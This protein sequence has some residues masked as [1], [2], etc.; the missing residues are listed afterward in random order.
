MALKI[1]KRIWR[2][3]D[4]LSQKWQKFGEFWSEP[5]KVS[6]VA[7]CLVFSANFEP[8]KVIFHDTRQSC[9]IWKKTNL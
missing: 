7:L 5:S 6:T 1:D 4:M 9:K 2:K 3:T 8:K